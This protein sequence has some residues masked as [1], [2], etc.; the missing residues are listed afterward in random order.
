PFVADLGQLFRILTGEQDVF[1]GFT[2]P[3]LGS[4]RGRPLHNTTLGLISGVDAFGGFNVSSIQVELP[5]SLVQGTTSEINVWATVSRPL[6]A[7]N[8]S[9][10]SKAGAGT[11]AAVASGYYLQFERMGQQLINTIFI[12]ANLKDAFNAGIPQNDMAAFGA[13]VPDAL[14]TTD[15]DG[16]GNTI[17]G[18]AAVLK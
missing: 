11:S 12:P 8:G 16:T 17:A 1:R 10:T 7:L 6:F 18:R 13:L 14:T 2:S 4:L 3:V 9:A 15:N 5:K